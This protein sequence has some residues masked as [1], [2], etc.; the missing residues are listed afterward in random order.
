MAQQ[1][2]KLRSALGTEPRMSQQAAV[3][4][5]R[6][7]P[8]STFRKVTAP[9]PRVT[10]MPQM[11]PG[12]KPAQTTTAA[13]QPG[14]INPQREAERTKFLSD[15]QR[16]RTLN[17]NSTEYAGLRSNI[18]NAGASL[19]YNPADVN[20][21]I[22]RYTAPGLTAEEANITYDYNMGMG[23]GST[24]PKYTNP[25]DQMGSGRLGIG[26]FEQNQFN[27]QVQPAVMP[28]L[29]YSQYQPGQVG[30]GSFMQN[31]FQPQAM[32]IQPTNF[33]TGMQQSPAMNQA[34]QIAQG[35][36]TGMSPAFK[37]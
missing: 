1:G 34:S 29:S 27:N 2:Q 23:T 8:A 12:P 16:L 25:M 30:I 37:R 3:G 36:M 33:T 9:A 15:L 4:Q 14:Q 28:Q 31:Q 10:S 20:S 5:A 19:R 13:G 26:Q 32:P 22:G 18:Q 17:P 7:L 35:G 6:Q 21:Y 11:Q 24:I